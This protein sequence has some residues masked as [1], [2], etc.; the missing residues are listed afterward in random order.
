MPKYYSPN[1]L[2][3][4]TCHGS[5]ACDYDEGRWGGGKNTAAMLIKEAEAKRRRE[6]VVKPG[7]GANPLKEDSCKTPPNVHL[8]DVRHKTFP[9]S[10]MASRKKCFTVIDVLEEVC[11]SSD[12]EKVQKDDHSA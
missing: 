9:R 12:E 6:A 5:P 1:L 4:P 3:I 2:Q 10:H 11:R 7:T 8:T